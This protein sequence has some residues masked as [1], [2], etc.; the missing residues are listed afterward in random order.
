MNNVIDFEAQRRRIWVNRMQKEMNA[1]RE[2]LNPQM[3]NV[4]RNMRE[5]TLAC[6]GVK[7]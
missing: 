1:K 5:Y 3:R 2:K 6:F 7:A 4:L